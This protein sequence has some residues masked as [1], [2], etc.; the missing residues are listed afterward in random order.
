MATNN[1]TN[2]SFPLPASLGGLGVASPTAHGIL[3]GEGSSAVTPIVLTAGQVLIGTTSSDPVGATL[4][5]GTGISITSVTG[6]ITI[7]ATGAS[8]GGGFT[9][10]DVTGT[11]QAIAAGNA[12]IADNAGLVTFTL[13]AS[14][15]LGDTFRVVWGTAAGGWTIHQNASQLIKLG[16]VSTTTGTGGS[17]SSS[18][19]GDGVCIV[20]IG[21]NTFE[22]LSSMGNITYV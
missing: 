7:N 8:A 1:S 10:T 2:S 6:S 11:T 21:S 5:A 9:W 3:V 19:V 12:Y 16:N 14:P 15:T 13:P 4:T 18:A 22:V 17:I 20:Y